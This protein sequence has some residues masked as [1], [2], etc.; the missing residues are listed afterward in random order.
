VRP[1]WNPRRSPVPAAAPRPGVPSGVLFDGLAEPE[2]RQECDDDDDRADDVNDVAHVRLLC[3][4][5]RMGSQWLSGNDD[6]RT[7]ARLDSP[8]ASRRTV[9][10][11]TGAVC[12]V[13]LRMQR[14]PRQVEQGAD[15]AGSGRRWTAASCALA[16]RRRPALPLRCS[17]AADV[18][19]RLH[20]AS[21]GLR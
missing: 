18:V 15:H 6:F 5:W 8:F 21:V 9:R 12:A 7:D 1:T 4:R 2:E 13:A 10:F 14:H 11:R 20:L 19:Y 17:R 3:V 16:Y